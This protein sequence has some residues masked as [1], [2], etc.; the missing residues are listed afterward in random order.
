MYGIFTY[1][2]AIFTVNGASG[3][4]LFYIIPM[5]LMSSS[6]VAATFATRDAGKKTGANRHGEF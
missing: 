5:S 4:D 6:E 3:P 1:I 2:W